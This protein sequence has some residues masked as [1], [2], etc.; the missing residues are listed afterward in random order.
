M[1]KRSER[2]LDLMNFQSADQA[3]AEVKKLA[4][5]LSDKE[6][7]TRSCIFDLHAAVEV[8]L[9]RIFYHTFHAHLFLSDEEEHNKKT[10]A[11]F[12]KM[13]E[14][15]G[16]QDIFRVLKPILLSWPYPD[17]DSIQAINETRNQAAHGNNLEKV[18][19]KN[20][21]P[22]NNA[23]CFAQMYFDVWAIKESMGKYFDRVI[24]RPKRT[25]KR[26]IDE[27]GEGLL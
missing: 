2:Y 7:L 12:E 23:D 11:D 14:R 4:S 10:V 27:Y 26:Y 25:L 18:R 6:H 15:L 8:E 5:S 24:E 22:F 9:K 17:F 13:I 19:Y 20:R 1:T 16:F 21:N 3:Y